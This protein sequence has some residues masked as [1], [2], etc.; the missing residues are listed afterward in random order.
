MSKYLPCDTARMSEDATPHRCSEC[1]FLGLRAN[2]GELVEADEDYRIEGDWNSLL[3]DS[4]PLPI[5]AAMRF[6]FVAEKA[7]QLVIES[8]DAGSSPTKTS[9]ITAWERARGSSIQEVQAYLD[10]VRACFPT[11]SKHGWTQHQPGFTPKEHREML[12]REW[13]LGFERRTRIIE[14][15]TL[16][17]TLVV[18]AVA[19]GLAFWIGRQTVS[20]V[21]NI[22]RV[23][24]ESPTQSTLDI[25]E[26]QPSEAPEERP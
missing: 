21:V 14:V 17:G 1:G 23:V 13:R 25:P 2:T 18:A 5:C 3:F 8:N 7:T 10:A 16:V 24:V 20:P 6:N 26:V 9:V 15:F 19:V 22:D 4:L 11:D 12:D